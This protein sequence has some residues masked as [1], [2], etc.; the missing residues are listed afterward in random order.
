MLYCFSIYQEQPRY[1][2]PMHLMGLLS[3]MGELLLSSYCAYSDTLPYTYFTLPNRECYAICFQVFLTLIDW[4][5]GAF[6][7]IHLSESHLTIS[8]FVISRIICLI[9]KTIS[10]LSFAPLCL[11]QRFVCS[12][13]QNGFQYDWWNSTI[14][15]CVR[16][17]T[18]IIYLSSSFAN[19]F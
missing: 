7:V 4:I 9:W 11:D 19:V 14:F 3:S 10:S 8:V 17:N 1:Y 12:F 18:C 2:A 16:C 6:T 13:D 5:Q 15:V